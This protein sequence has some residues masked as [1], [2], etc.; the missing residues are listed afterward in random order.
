[1]NNR[2][3]LSKTIMSSFTTSLTMTQLSKVMALTTL[4]LILTACGGG[5]SSNDN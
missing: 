2:S 1:M 5:S 4:G 3:D